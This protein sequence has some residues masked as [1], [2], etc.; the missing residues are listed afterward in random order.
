M[1]PGIFI[2]IIRLLKV[3]M[4]YIEKFIIN[5]EKYNFLTF[6]TDFE[7]SLFTAFNK[8]F[9]KDNKIKHIGC[10]YHYLQNI[11]KFMQKHGYTSKE[12]KQLY[13]KILNICK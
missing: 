13:D 10:Y 5:K 12:K 8:V 4:N 6:K 3:I 7:I 1:I 2:K 11:Y 9:N